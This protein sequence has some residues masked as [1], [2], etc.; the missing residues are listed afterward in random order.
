MAVTD[1]FVAQ[2]AEALDQLGYAAETEENIID[3]LDNL[4]ENTTLPGIIREN[5]VLKGYFT[6]SLPVLKSYV[7]G[8]VDPAVASANAATANANTATT[9]ANTA[10][11]AANTATAGAEKVNAQINGMTVTITNRQGTSTSVNIGESC[12]YTK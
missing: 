5:G 7:D 9:A 12:S 8:K 11:A 6:F 4:S 2:V 3:S 10:T 1:E